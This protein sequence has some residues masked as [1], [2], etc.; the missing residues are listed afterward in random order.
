M[1]TKIRIPYT[2]EYIEIRRAEA[3]SKALDVILPEGYT[4]LRKTSTQSE[5]GEANRSFVVCVTDDR[6]TFRDV[7]GFAREPE[8]SDPG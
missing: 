3:Y 7:D 5:T 8:K 2:D 4:I 6:N 1:M